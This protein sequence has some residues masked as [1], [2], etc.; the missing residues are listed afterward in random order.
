MSTPTLLAMERLVTSFLMAQDGVHKISMGVLYRLQGKKRFFPDTDENKRKEAPV[1][2]DVN[3]NGTSVS[4]DFGSIRILNI[5][6]SSNIYTGTLDPAVDM[7][8]LQTQPWD[9]IMVSTMREAGAPDS[10]P[11]YR[12]L[13]YRCNGVD[14]TLRHQ[15]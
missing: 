14:I 2:R 3:F 1:V 4:V 10:A 6:I 7:E 15:L 9:L 12:V 11:L 13:N 8:P 5:P